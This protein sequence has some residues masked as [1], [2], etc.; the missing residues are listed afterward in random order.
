M[1]NIDKLNLR[2]K[3][4][5]HPFHARLSMGEGFVNDI[6]PIM[7]ESSHFFVDE[8]GLHCVI[9]DTYDANATLETEH[10]LEVYDNPNGVQVTLGSREKHRTRIFVVRAPPHPAYAPGAVPD[11]E[12]ICYSVNDFSP[13]MDGR[14]AE[15]GQYSGVEQTWM[16]R[17]GQS[18][19][20]VSKNLKAAIILSRD[21]DNG[22]ELSPV[23]DPDADQDDMRDALR[24]VVEK[25]F[26]TVWYEVPAESTIVSEDFI[27][28]LEELGAS[29]VHFCPQS[30]VDPFDV[31]L[32]S[33]S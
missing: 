33:N 11:N 19:Y 26:E 21:N 29:R 24:S 15:P 25:G 31:Y 8:D 17:V 14:K 22:L 12:L 1:V 27:A 18:M 7:G 32:L 28:V 16:P 2:F 9:T 20:G 6:Y 3:S 4:H 13:L 5:L 30:T 23:V 10:Q